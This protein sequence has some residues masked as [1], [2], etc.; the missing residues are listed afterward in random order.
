MAADFDFS[1]LTQLGA[2]LGDV[3]DKVGPNVRKAIIGTSM[4]VKKAWQEPLKGSSQLFGLPSAI[5]F[6]IRTAQMFGVSVI[7]SEIGF[8]KGKTQ[9]ALGNIS[10]FGSPTI[11][12]RGYGIAA[13]EANQADFQHGL[14]EATKD[15][16]REAGL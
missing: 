6:D 12:G 8:D 14:E 15:A 7:E 5:S 1:Q 13:L 9:G 3:G 11:A 16:E 2:D 4:G 10:E